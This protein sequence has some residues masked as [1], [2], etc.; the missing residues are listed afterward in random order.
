MIGP[1][2]L[3]CI[4]CGRLWAVGKYDQW[5]EYTCPECVI[6][7]APEELRN[8]SV[9]ELLDIQRGLEREL[10]SAEAGTAQHDALFDVWMTI[11]GIASAKGGAEE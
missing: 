10:R 4:R 1:Y 5:G 6:R 11:D 3:R 9:D 8:L 2:L 7:D